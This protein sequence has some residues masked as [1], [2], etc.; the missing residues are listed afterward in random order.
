MGVWYGTSSADPEFSRNDSGISQALRS[1]NFGPDDQNAEGVDELNGNAGYDVLEGYGGADWIYG[2]ADNDDLYGNNQLYLYNS[3][4]L[5]ANWADYHSAADSGDHIYG[6]AGFDRLFGQEGDDQLFGQDDNDE[7]YG[8]VGN[9]F[10]NGGVGLNRIDGGDGVDLVSYSDLQSLTSF[11]IEVNLDLGYANTRYDVTYYTE[12]DLF[13][14]ENVQGSNYWD[15]ISGDDFD[16][17]LSGLGGGDELRGGAGDDEIYGGA[18]NDLLETGAG[19]NVVDG[20]DGFDTLTYANSDVEVYVHLDPFNNGVGVAAWLIDYDND[21]VFRV[22]NNDTIMGVEA[23]EGSAFNDRL[24]GNGGANSLK[25]LAGDD[26]LD[27][28]GGPDTLTGG[29]GDDLYFVNSATDKV[30]ELIGEGDDTVAVEVNYVLAA[31]AEVETLRTRVNAG[32][33]P[34][35]LTGNEFGQT[36]YGNAGVNVINGKGGVDVMRGL[37]GN[38]T[39]YVDSAADQVF[40]GS[41]GG[42]DMVAASVSYTLAGGQEVETLRTTSNSGTGAINLTGN[43]LHQ[44]IIGNAGANILHTGGGVADKM[45]GLGGNDTYRVYNSGDVIVETAS[46]GTAD[47]VMSAVDYVLTAGAYIERLATNG[48]AG[49]STIDLTGNDLGQEVVGNTGANILNGKG[50]NDVIKGL[51]GKDTLTGGTGGDSFVF[52]T[53]LSA[54]TNVDTIT[55]FNPAADTIQLENAIFSKLT[56]TGTLSSS[57]FR[58]NTTGTAQDA[59]DYIVYETDTGKLFY[60]SNGNASGGSIQF[61]ILTGAPTITAADFVV[62]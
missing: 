34:L 38:D 18:D 59:N 37:G 52:N 54:S 43:A 15:V 31:G 46:Q 6:G 4:T 13:S 49:T 9:D 36:I 20:E 29:E 8:D 23:V 17:I 42:A 56:S 5:K 19:K 45:S 41:G 30:V 26:Y 55:D 1:F 51:G 57:F 2:N 11:G 28:G 48:T 44:E 32:T 22:E 39:Y 7:L 47:L 58:A 35:N 61:A 62:I 53:A 12:D 10:L 50:G 16:N 21:G 3:T 60:D 40:E 27:G 14:V 33:I 25:G 24:F